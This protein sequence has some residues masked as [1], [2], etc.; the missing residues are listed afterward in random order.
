MYKVPDDLNSDFLRDDTLIM[1]SFNANQI[2]LHFETGILIT[3]EGE[4]IISIVG[5]EHLYNVYPVSYE[6]GLLELIEKK[7]ERT[8][9]LNSKKDL[10]IHFENSLCVTLINSDNYESYQ[11]KINDRR[12]IL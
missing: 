3:L 8:E 2:Y 11:V 12:F 1:V 6:N 7:V 9:V 4:Y 5:K 10:T